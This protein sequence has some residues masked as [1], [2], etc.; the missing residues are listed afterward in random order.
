MPRKLLWILASVST[1]AFGTFALAHWAR[2]PEY[3]IQELYDEVNAEQM[4]SAD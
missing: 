1:L 2:G 4:R 3:T